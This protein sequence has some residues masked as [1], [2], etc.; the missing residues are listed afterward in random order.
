MVRAAGFDL[1]GYL[2][3]STS[4]NYVDVYGWAHPSNGH[5]YALIGNN[6]T[7]LH[8]VDVSDPT[9]PFEAGL[10]P[11]VPR[12]DMKTFG[13]LVYTVDGLP[14]GSG[15]IVDLSNP[16]N[17]VVVGSFTGGHNLWIDTKGFMYVAL[18]GLTCYD[19]NDDPTE[20]AFVWDMPGVDGHDSYVDGDILFDFRGYAGTFIYDV[21]D[22]YAPQGLGSI[23]DPLIEFHHQGRLTADGR[24]LYLCD[25]F[26]VTPQPDITIWDL[27][28]IWNPVKV[29]AIYDATATAHYCYVVGNTLAVAYFTAGFKLYDITAPTF[30]T[31]ID[32]YD[33]SPM[34]GEGVF[35]GA[36]GCFAF[37]PGGT[38]YV[39]DRP[40]GLY[41][42]QLAFATGIERA[43]APALSVGPNTPN[44]FGA[45]TTIPFRLE[46]SGDASVA[47][48]DARGARV[49]EL[50]SAF[51]LAGEHA[52]E[53]DGRDDD[54]RAVASGVYLCRVR[55][56]GRE[57]IGKLV[58]VR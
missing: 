58:L 4:N 25:E 12:Y 41:V 57:A 31:L 37:G 29:G 46:H 47:V 6:G 20:P 15:G 36:Y 5:S 34:S 35:L 3:P 22:R 40:N 14:G 18:P 10:V 28:S 44:P 52:V 56:G 19:L 21:T 32:Q 43:S 7:G 55:A 33:T 49:R 16:A 48:Y 2:D 9:N 30:P 45:S 53:W 23:T 42:F 11:T 27:S 54:G 1:V 17:P 50:Q 51:T 24:Y 26:A 39:S 13:N 8:I 38:M